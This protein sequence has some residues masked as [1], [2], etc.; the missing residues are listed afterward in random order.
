MGGAG[1]ARGYL[2]RGRL[3]AERFVPDPS[4]GGGRLYRTGDLVRWRGGELEYLGRLD[5]Q[6]KVRGYRVELGE[7]EAV[8]AA[9]AGVRQAVAVVREDVPGDRRLVA[10]VVPEVPGEGER[11]RLRRAQVG[12]WRGVFDVAQAAAP[13]GEADFN[14]SGW[15]S[16][17]TGAAIPGEEMRLW[18]EATAGRIAALGPR[19][20]LEIG[21]GTGLLAWRLAPLCESY[22][23]TDFSGRTLEALGGAIG[24]RGWGVRLL[25]READDF[26]GLGPGEFDVV[27]INSVVQ[28]FPD[29]GYLRSVLD[30]ALRVLSPGGHLFVGDVRSLPLL[31]TFHHSIAQFK[32]E[33]S[34]QVTLVADAA[35]GD[36]ELVLDP[37][38]FQRVADESPWPISVSIRPRG[39][40][41][42]NEMALYRCDVVFHKSR[43]RDES[44][45]L[46]WQDW[47]AYRAA[48]VRPGADA[49][50]W[51]L[52]AVMNSR[53]A[54]D[55]ETA[56][57][58]SVAYY[59]AVDP[60]ELSQ[61]SGEGWEMEASWLSGDPL[62]RFDA[63][64]WRPGAAPAC[65]CGAYL[66]PWPAN[67]HRG[68]EA[69][70]PL[71]HRV[72]RE[73]RGH[74]EQQVAAALPSHM[75]PSLLVVIDRIPRTPS[76]K[77]DRAQLPAPASRR[78]R[79]GNELIP[80]RGE[81]EALVASFWQ[82]LLA[83]DVVSRTD[84]F[85]EVGGHSLVATEL[86]SRIREAFSVQLSLRNVFES[87]DLAA[88]AEVVDSLR[89]SGLAGAD[90][91]L[92][93]RAGGG[94]VAPLS[95]SQRRL[96][97]LDQ[98]VPGSAFYNV[99]VAYRLVGDLD[100][101]ALEG[102][103]S[104]VVARHEVL[105]TSFGAR[106][107]AL[108]GQP[109]QVVGEPWPVV[110]AVTEAAT[111]QE[112]RDL[113]AQEAGR[114]F[115]LGSGRLLRVRL[116][117]LGPDDHVLLVTMHHIV[118]D[119]WSL[120]V[121]L[122]EVSGFYQEL[123]EGGEPSG[124]ALPVQ[125]ADF[126][127]WQREWLSGEV[128]EGQLGYWREQL[129][130]LEEVLEL[131]LDRVRPPVLS[132]AG[133]RVGFTVPAGVAEGLRGLGRECGATLFMVLLAGFDVLVGRWAGRE[134]VAVGSPIAGRNRSEVEG[135]IGFF[136]N[137]L[138]LRVGLGGEPS[139]RELVGRVREAAL[140]AYA[141]Q[142]VPFEALV[143]DLAP[144][145]DLSRN[146][147]VQ[148]MFQLQSLAEAR[149]RIRRVAVASFSRPIETTRFDM[150]VLMVDVDEGLR[151]Q[152]VFSTELFDP[153]TVQRFADSYLQVLAAMVAAP[154]ASASEVDLPGMP[155]R[156]EGGTRREHEG[157]GHGQNGLQPP[158]GGAGQ[159]S[160]GLDDA[161]LSGCEQDIARIWMDLLKIEE[162]RRSDN[163][164]DL[165]GHSLLA[166]QA[167]SRIREA[168]GK[169]V[170]VRDLFI[171][172]DLRSLA[173]HVEE[174]SAASAQKIISLPR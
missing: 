150:S 120:G 104:A 126:S 43:P 123:A 115:D 90:R 106:V 11:E 99:P 35:S 152:V 61:L 171:T 14:V 34:G 62:G 82:E 105:R 28:Y 78:M 76:G 80:P 95:F 156:E 47:N 42:Y 32:T 54:E 107:D 73:L 5:D 131:P 18:A 21:C 15:T 37:G 59:D 138:V 160:G 1:V 174:L 169:E 134:D 161:P 98:L 153:E 166:T 77:V 33:H 133:A 75:Q 159:P 154:D 127:V 149:P 83:V 102:A 38:F 130:G 112:A 140:G 119:A 85:F 86:V 145:R 79:T 141:H 170:G 19:R 36:D 89:M 2:G 17:Y 128:L 135:L 74:L 31:D 4:G 24:G 48:G 147:L 56:N 111:E 30:G 68:D 173:A 172:M 39:E 114:P 27:V 155:Q 45:T 109:A 63:V 84:N 96:W 162:V 69:T 92:V 97:F 100:V 113:A 52:S 51:G 124:E 146:P 3:T 20:V 71:A 118:C 164:F 168:T 25:C 125:Y 116:V 46:Q 132:Y 67:G 40:S 91:P 26:S 66:G 129:G 65:E 60:A 94:S 121:L 110:I 122:R 12:D 9:Q 148:V 117:R 23:G 44:P 49:G 93:R 167:A 16:S 72:E 144:V 8:L 87:P 41:C 70:F 64:F 88:L 103:F 158:A 143:E 151:G 108:G 163:F 157:A 22:T 137:T 81:T 13:G 50:V 142:D 29:E 165:G 101:G 7:V 58:E 139:F 53:L 6:V 10:Y 55:L 57:G 136:V